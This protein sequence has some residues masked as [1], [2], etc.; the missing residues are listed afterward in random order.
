MSTSNGAEIFTSSGMQTDAT[1][2]FDV[3][4]ALT[5][6]AENPSTGNCYK[7]TL[8]LYNSAGCYVEHSENFCMIHPT[9][10]IQDNGQP[11]CE[12]TPFQLTATG[13]PSD[14]LYT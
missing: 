11:H 7:V 10:T 3:R 9:V 4:D 5:A 8:R 6:A 14:W 2:S 12:G 1:T 13:A